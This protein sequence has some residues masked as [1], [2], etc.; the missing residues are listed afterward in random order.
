M[1]LT[2]ERAPA[3]VAAAAH[4]AVLEGDETLLVFA[5]RTNEGGAI[6]TDRRLLA[7]VGTGAATSV[8]V[9]HIESVTMNEIAI[10]LTGITIPNLEAKATDGRILALGLGQK[11]EVTPLLLVVGAAREGRFED[12]LRVPLSGPEL[13]RILE[14]A[15]TGGAFRIFQ[16][17]D[18]GREEDLK[19]LG[20]IGLVVPVFA[21]VMRVVAEFAWGSCPGLVA[22]GV[23]W[24]TLLL[25]PLVFIYQAIQAARPGKRRMLWCING[26]FVVRKQIREGHPLWD[27]T[28]AKFRDVTDEGMSDLRWDRRIATVGFDG[29]RI[30][31]GGEKQPSADI[32]LGDLRDQG[33]WRELEEML[34]R[35]A[36][37]VLG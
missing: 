9:T 24:L 17:P 15:E 36:G 19:T 12:A 34:R 5:D 26:L 14:T 37:M 20:I 2:R 32:R 1:K 3:E 10:P 35:P 33:E 6:V 30:A 29:A 22:I 8:H 18:R 13:D 7:W 28:S 16:G 11:R 4:G 27:A 23:F 31:L 21:I 25:G